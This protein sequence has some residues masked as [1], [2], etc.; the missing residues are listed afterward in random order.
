[1][2]KFFFILAFCTSNLSWGQNNLQFNSAVFNSIEGISNQQVV[3][4]IVVP[5]GKVLKIESTSVVAIE[6]SQGVIPPIH[7]NQGNFE[8]IINTT[9]AFSTEKNHTL[10]IWL[11]AGSYNVRLYKSGGQQYHNT[12]FSYSGVLFNLVP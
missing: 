10:P 5:V 12:S 7:A 8:A 11:P 4:T 1:M 2:K 6:N 3:G 9:I